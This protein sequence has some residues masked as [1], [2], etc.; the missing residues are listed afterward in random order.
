MSKRKLT[1]KHNKRPRIKVFNDEANKENVVPKPSLHL[2][3]PN[4]SPNS[5]ETKVDQLLP[6]LVKHRGLA[7]E[8]INRI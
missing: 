8:L 6:K 3:Y 4:I 1:L 5:R 7:L 2:D